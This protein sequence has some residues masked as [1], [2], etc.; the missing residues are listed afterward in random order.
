MDKGII[1][2]YKTAIEIER[3]WFTGGNSKFSARSKDFHTNR[4]YARGEHT[5]ESSMNLLVPPNSGDE[6]YTNYDMSPI[7]ILP[8]F[9]DVIVNSALPQLY[10]VKAEA[11][12]QYHTDLRNDEKDRLM[13]RMNSKNLDKDMKELFGVDMEDFNGGGD[14]PHSEEEVDMRMGLEFKPNAEIA[15]EEVIKYVMKINDYDETLFSLLSDAVDNGQIA[16]RTFLHPTKGTCTERLD[17]ADMV[18]SHSKKRNHSDAWYFGVRKRMTVEDLQ[19]LTKGVWHTTKD[20]WTILDA[21]LLKRLKNSGVNTNHEN[22]YND[23]QNSGS[24][25][26]QDSNIIDALYYTYKTVEKVYWKKKKLSNG[27][28][29][30]TKW[31]GEYNNEQLIETE[32]F[33]EKKEVWRE[34]YKILNTPYAFGAR[35]CDN[36]MYIKTNGVWKVKSPISLYSIGLYEGKSKGIIERCITLVNKMQTTEIKIQQLVASVKPSGIRIDVSKINNIKTAGGSLDYKSIMRI[37][38]ETGNEIYHSGN[39]DMNEFSQGNIHEL[40]NGVVQGI[41]DLVSIQ[42]NYLNQLRDAIGLPQGADASSPHPD[43]AVRVQEIVTR[44][45]NV[46]LRHILDAVLKITGMTSENIFESVKYVFKHHPELTESYERAVGKVNVDII[47][48]LKDLKLYDLGIF[49][50][51]KPNAQSQTELNESI[52]I[53]LQQNLIDIDDAYET[54]E[55]GKT[56]TKLAHLFLKISK[57]RKMKKLEDREDKKAENES[58]RN[59]ALATHK[60]DIET[61]KR[62]SMFVVNREE[63]GAEAEAKIAVA[64]ELHSL[65]MEKMEKKFGYDKALK[66]MEVFGQSKRLDESEFR[67]DVRQDNN[68]SDKSVLADQKAKGLGPQS[69]AK[70]HR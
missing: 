58:E 50:E 12:D 7:Q 36:Q 39:G 45:S 53:S 51:L 63:T 25:S 43:T 60:A 21:P 18:F 28:F 1:K 41:M 8:K 14:R 64:R 9:K 15:A 20:E 10:N 31:E 52:N 33:S 16:T 54:R 27:G 55:I 48:A 17:T 34:G 69:F 22:N 5:V 6:A 26:L 11:V 61:Q 40:R 62:E 30:I 68:N 38:N 23:Q 70:I 44:N 19:T 2:D 46:A 56:N 47:K 32:I 66:E 13:R 65:E 49:C 4:K 37:Y 59:K 29:K 57:E 67:K 35:S 3:E 42:N 24:S